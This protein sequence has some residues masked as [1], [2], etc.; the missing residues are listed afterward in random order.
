MTN[1]ENTIK[2]KMTGKVVSAKM[3]KT[4][5]V[6]VNRLKEHPRYKKRYVVSKRY[7]AHN[8]NPEAGEGDT[9][10]IEETR[11]IS[12]DKRWRVVKILKKASAMPDGEQVLKLD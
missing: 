6:A 10:L 11:P 12:R 7:K 2:R 3:Q 9:V 1:K 8:E 5:V 4:V